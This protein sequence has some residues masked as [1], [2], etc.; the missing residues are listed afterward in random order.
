[1]NTV[2]KFLFGILLFFTIDLSGQSPNF[3]IVL[4]PMDIPELGGLQS[5]SFGQ[6]NGKW[7]ILGGRLDGLHRRQPW[8]SFDV[9]G[10]N[11]QVIV[12]D[13]VAKQKWTAPLTSLPEAVQ[14]QLS[15]TNMEFYQEGNYLYIVGGYGY[16]P[17]EEDHITYSSLIAADVPAVINAVVNNLSFEAFFRQF[18]DDKLAV[19][20]GRLEKIYDTYNLVGGYR[21]IGRYNPMGP[22]HGPVFIQE[23]TN[24]IRRFTLSD[25]GENISI[26]HLPAITDADNL[27]RRDFN[28]V[29]QIMPDG[30]E[31]LTAFSGV[32]QQEAD[33]PFLNCVNI[34]S[35]GYVV[36]NSFVQY[37]NHY[38]CP[39]IPLYSATENEMQT[40]FFGGIA[41]YYDDMGSLVRDDNVP[42]VKTI[43]KVV[44]EADG[45]MT[46][47]KLPVEL[48]DYS[49][50]G[51][52]FIQAEG[53]KVFPNGVIKLDDMRSD[54]TLLGYIYGG[55]R[56]SEKNI[57]WINDGTQSVAS[58]RIFKVILVKN[59]PVG[60]QNIDD[61]NEGTLKVTVF[62]N[63]NSSIFSVEF[64]LRQATD[65]KVRVH[66][67]NGKVIE[68]FFMPSLGAGIHTFELNAADLGAGSK[69]MYLLTLETDYEKAT[70]KFIVDP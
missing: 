36:N 34:N 43:A 40:V 41:Q 9:A 55:I 3:E 59:D 5:Y 65:V 38:H 69:G 25:D 51:A 37:Y 27:H 60:T 52:E 46:E 39:G 54:S 19:T 2:E 48:P 42:F 18:K 7:L 57:F 15:S 29:P 30:T 64:F 45:N 4:E 56:S 33:L 44:R 21:L 49:G 14:E 47:Y 6:H 58:N 28:V 68:S 66:D 62:P 16:S 50:A 24:Q 70:R 8:A 63:P 17:T 35:S 67:L 53:L 20:G 10:H 13:P 23:Y 11:N 22:T 12:V 31:G 26:T 61:K 1:M 32:F